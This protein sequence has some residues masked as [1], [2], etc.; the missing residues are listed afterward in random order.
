MA[1]LP[2][3]SRLAGAAAAILLLLLIASPV[4]ALDVEVSHFTLNNGLQVV[5]I[6]DRRAPVVTH[7]VW[8]RVGS[9]DEPQG[10]AG[11]AHFLEHLLFKGTKTLPAGEFSLIVRRHGGEDNAFTSHDYTAY[12]QHIS[13]DRLDVVMALEADRMANLVLTEEDVATE[14][15][16]VREERRSE[17][18]NDPAALLSEQVS[19]ALYLAHPYRKPVIG[20]MAEV[21]GLTLDDAMAFYRIHYTPANAIVVVAGDVAADDVRVLTEKHYGALVNTAEPDLRM[22]TPEPEPIA[23]R[24]VIMADD[25]AASPAMQ[26][27]YLVPGY[28]TAGP[29]EAEALEV[30]AKVLGGGTTSR[31][32]RTLVV[33]A[34]AAAYAEASYS[35]DGLDGGS[36]AIYAAPNPGGSLD[37]VEH[38]VDAVIAGIIADGVSEAELERARNKLVADTVYALDDQFHLAYIFGVALTNGRTVED[39]LGWTQAVEQVTADDVQTAAAKFLRIER[40]AT[41]LL[42]PE[43]QGESQR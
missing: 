24:R 40:S 39:V 36:F 38:E 11:I 25:R 34:N 20:W 31:L 16:V 32:Y 5:V 30:L 2:V 8:Y 28:T 9:A 22:R 10:K 6:P 41:G 14:L 7:M 12:Y 37:R 1:P 43:D 21:E 18:E 26:R 4:R 17:V 35:G 27:H 13:K 3:K 23:A 19:A 15:E 29:G 33:E 42:M